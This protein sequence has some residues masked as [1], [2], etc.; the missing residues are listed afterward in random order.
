MAWGDLLH[1]I[2]NMPGSEQNRKSLNGSVSS[3]SIAQS[4][5]V[6]LALLEELTFNFGHPVNKALLGKEGPIRL[7]RVAAMLRE[8]SGREK[9]EKIPNWNA[10]RRSQDRSRVRINNEY[11]LEVPPLIL[12]R[13]KA[14]KTDEPHWFIYDGCHRALAYLTE[15]FDGRDSSP[16]LLKAIF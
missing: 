14:V 15:E 7:G 8:E 10:A 13:H 16:C 4:G 3:H 1:L 5:P 9:V 2:D 11:Q 6:T 12:L